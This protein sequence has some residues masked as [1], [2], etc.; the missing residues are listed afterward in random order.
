MFTPCQPPRS[1]NSATSRNQDAVAAAS[2]TALAV[3]AFA[4]SS[5]GAPLP[6]ERMFGQ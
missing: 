4:N 2:R 3:I 6:L 1:S 5:I